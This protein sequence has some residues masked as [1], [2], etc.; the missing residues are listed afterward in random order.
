MDR[1][2]LRDWAIENEIHE[3]VLGFLVAYGSMSDH[4]FI[5]ADLKDWN[6]SF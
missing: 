4:G 6:I 5:Y 1:A 3:N 2:D